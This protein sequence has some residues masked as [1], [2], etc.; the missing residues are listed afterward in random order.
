MDSL[1]TLCRTARTCGMLLAEKMLDRGVDDFAV[2]PML[3]LELDRVRPD[4]PQN[5]VDAETLKAAYI[6]GC[7]MRLAVRG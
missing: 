5:D 1:E 6:D 3:R 7:R 2:E 4:W